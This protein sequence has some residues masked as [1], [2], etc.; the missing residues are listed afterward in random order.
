MSQILL[1]IY[2]QQYKQLL[3][4]LGFKLKGRR[5][6]KLYNNEIIEIIEMNVHRFGHS[7]AIEI[8]IPPLCLGLDFTKE[9]YNLFQYG[10]LG[11][12]DDFWWD[13][14]PHDENSIINAVEESVK[15]VKRYALIYSDRFTDT[16]KLYE[17]MNFCEMKMFGEISKN[18]GSK[19]FICLKLKR[20]DEALD[21]IGF[22]EKHFFHCMEHNR[23]LYFNDYCQ[24][25][26][27]YKQYCDNM[28]KE[29]QQYYD[30]RDA[31]HKQ[32]YLYLDNIVKSNEE[33]SM[34]SC[35]EIFKMVANRI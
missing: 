15:V 35:K 24:R 6:Y 7:F 27:E 17:F 31:I 5:F 26:E 30:I 34:K 28:L 32:D 9:Q 8:Y 11:R 3:L 25:P 10:L 33:I 22:V 14:D 18:D 2:K 23:D 16:E 1:N 19:V 4:P 20:Y 21:L 12:G 29:L 13:I